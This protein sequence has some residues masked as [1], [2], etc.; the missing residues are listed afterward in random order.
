[1]AE[2]FDPMAIIAELRQN[3]TGAEPPE[4]LVDSLGGWPTIE[5]LA[6][7]LV[8]DPLL[9]LAMHL[10]IRDVDRATAI[11]ADLEPFRAA[12]TALA[13][14]VLATTD[15]GQFAAG[16]DIICASG[17]L[18][19][20]VGAQVAAACVPLAVA[21]RERGDAPTNADVLRHA[22]A[23]EGAA[24]LAVVGHGSKYALIALLEKVTEPQPV[25]YAR[26][27]ARTVG[28]AYDHWIV[29]D[30]VV[31][32]ID[33]L[34][35]V[36]AP[37]RKTAADEGVLARDEEFRL[38]IAGDASWTKANV[39]LVRAL[40]ATDSQQLIE[41]LDDAIESLTFVADSDDRD[42]AVALKSAMV[43]LR[44]LLVSLRAA[45]PQDAAEWIAS[46]SDAEAA[47]RHRLEF[48]FHAQGLNH[49][50][51][52]RKRVVL[53]GWAR[54]VH[55]LAWLRDQL[56]RDSLY[57]AAVVLDD[58]LAIYSASNTYEVT[59]N[60]GGVEQ[61]LNVMRPAIEGGFAAR[62]GLLRNLADH[63]AVLRQRV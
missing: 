53:E 54:F 42:D 38:D 27:V 26:A 24:R 3:L 31:G 48:E 28:L 5:A 19:D 58:I 51:G 2:P 10:L 44:G 21:P 25:R 17:T 55:D 43:L 1:M 34:T 9:I 13:G 30:D 16:L 50:S 37:T 22:V 33:I 11:G 52:S 47:A 32:V 57:Q 14:A 18:V 36:T 45:Q 40:R 56:D 12:A 6:P 7:N 29:D 62:T 61:V 23:L 41:R 4:D 46:L 8:D 59:R 63:T 39:D 15:P 49:W 60:G 20:L 35:G